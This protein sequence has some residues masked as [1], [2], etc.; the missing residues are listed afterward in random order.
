MAA[1]DYV[2]LD[3]KGREKKGTLEGDSS[4]QVRQMLRDQSMVPLSVEATVGNKSKEGGNRTSRWHSPGLSA[5]DLAL[6][7]RQMATLVQAGLP[8]EE[9]MTA[10]AQQSEKPKQRSMLLAV[11][12]K[13]LEGY[14]LADSLSEY[15]RAFPQLYRATVAAGEHAG[16]LDLVLNRLADYT[17][18]S[19]ESKTKVQMALIYPV[20]LIS[21]S[22]LIVAGLMGYVVPDV[23]K[24]FV[25]TGQSLPGLTNAMISLSDFVV[26][27]GLMVFAVVVLLI[28]GF[29]YALRNDG[30]RESYHR[31]LLHTPLIKRLSRGTN[32]A[33]FAST[34]SILTSS[35]VPLVDAMKIA[36]EVMSND[37]MKIQV[38]DA[39]KKVA[40]GASLK[41]AL[42]QTGYFPPM[43]LHMIASGEASGE[44]DSMLERTSTMQEKEYENAIT[45]MIGLFEPAMLVVM[46][47]V[48]LTIMLAIM[49]PILNLNQLVT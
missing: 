12:G 34:L 19:Q 5:K 4:R 14:S 27:Y 15:P 46:G 25:D 48:V 32:T 18:A 43:M 30:F 28:I 49:L 39:T 23:V 6:I 42:D 36:G 33:R 16:H 7:T 9:V 11:R 44:L 13:V 41:N 21:L 20:I 45:V 8:I 22:I 3:Q 10:V 29:N 26:D 40:E 31:R 1:F 35:G 2:A 17:E 38:R 37:W 47:L 24:V